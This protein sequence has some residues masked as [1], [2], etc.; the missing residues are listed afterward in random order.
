V[1]YN[2]QY[3][4]D[5]SEA[6]K[7]LN[8]AQGMT[9]AYDVGAGEYDIVLSTGPM[10]K[11]A[12]QEAFRA[13]TM[14]INENPEM[15]LP[16]VGD[17]WAKN[18]DFP[19]ADVLADRFKKQLPP[20]L[21]D[22]DADDLQSKYLQAQTQIQQLTNSHNLMLQELSRAD[23]TIRTKRMEI[24]SRE[25]IALQNNWTA[26]MVQRMKSHDEAAQAL[27]DAE[28]EAITQRLQVLHDNMSVVDDAGAPTNTPELSPQVEPR[29][30]P[31]VPAAPTPR[32]Q[33][34]Q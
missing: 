21:Q 31:V 2:P 34:V 27:M 23:D 18:A 29:V 32:P 26:L 4:S 16:L 15:M 17:I 3:G 22:T 25:R 24:E 10:Y 8:A 11:T 33:P 13:L 14:V 20:N 7:L 28:L 19:D 6:R 30:Q 5:P 12:R 1:I 9:I